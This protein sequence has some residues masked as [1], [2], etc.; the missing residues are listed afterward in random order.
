MA[1]P[2]FAFVVRRN[3]SNILGEGGEGALRSAGD[4]NRGDDNAGRGEDLTVAGTF[5]EDDTALVAVW[6]GAAM[7]G[8]DACG[9]SMRPSN[10]FPD[11]RASNLLVPADPD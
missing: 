11:P 4:G 8:G 7:Y 10:A 2:I 1:S 9:S 6:I 3:L 5:T